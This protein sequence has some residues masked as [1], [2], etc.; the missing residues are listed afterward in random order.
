MSDAVGNLSGTLRAACLAA[1]VLLAGSPASALSIDSAEFG[2]WYAACDNGRVCSAFA[3]DE[4]LA[5]WAYLRV[6]R[7]AAADAA[8]RI[9]VSVP[10]G[11]GTRYRLSLSGQPLLDQPVG[12]DEASYSDVRLIDLT[13]VIGTEALVEGL[14]AAE[15]LVVEV[16]AGTGNPELP[17]SYR[18]S[19]RGAEAALAWMDEIQMRSGTVT[20]LAARGGAPAESIPPPPA[21]PV[22]HAAHPWSPPPAALDPSEEARQKGVELCGE[23]ETAEGRMEPLS[24]GL[25]LHI[26][27]CRLE[28]GAYN[29]L[30]ALWVSAPDSVADGW[31]PELL[32]PEVEAGDGGLSPLI[33]NV[34]FDPEALRLSTVYK[35]RGFGDCGEA[36]EHVWDGEAFRLVALRLMEPCRGVPYDDWPILLRAEVEVGGGANSP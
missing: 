14:G 35:S 12:G 30:F 22:A 17:A 28:S 27:H 33:S 34:R 2:D 7:D 10:G 16:E 25:V 21:L 19:L 8:P 24:E 26:Y 5:S 18:I 15:A 36:A 4:S 3:F 31:E 11:A 13:A 23:D 9:T 32:W 6:D 20:A 1:A 29:A